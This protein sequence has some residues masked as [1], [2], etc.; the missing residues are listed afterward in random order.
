MLTPPT[1]SDRGRRLEQVFLDAVEEPAGAARDARLR[2]A[3]GDD[4]ALLDDA[5][6]LLAAH[7]ANADGLFAPSAE[8]SEGAAVSH[9]EEAPLSIGGYDVV[10]YV[11]GGSI[12]TVYE[13]RH[14]TTGRRAAVKLIRVGLATARQRARFQV[15]AELL[16]RLADPG[17]ARLYDAGEAAVTY[18]DGQQARRVFI[19]MEFVDG[20][21][22]V[23]HCRAARLPLADRVGLMI[24]TARAVQHAHERGVI[25]RDLK[26][27]HVIVA[28][29]DGRPRVVD[30]G[31]ATVTDPDAR[32]TLTGTVMGTPAYMSPEQRAGHRNQVGPATDVYSL[33]AV[34]Y[35]M[36]AD[37]R[38]VDAGAT[39]MGTG[40]PPD[41]RRLRSV[42]DDVPQD[43]DAVIHKAV[44]TDPAD[45]YPTARDLAD[46]LQR[47]ADSLPVRA[48]PPSA[49][50][51]ARLQARRRPR[52]TT[53]VSVAAV[54]G[55]TLGTA[56]ALEAVRANRAERATLAQLRVATG[57][58]VRADH[59]AR[60][61]AAVARFLSDQIIGRADA[62]K[63][64]HDAGGAVPDLT[65]RQAIDRAAARLD[66]SPFDGDAE[67]EVAVRRAVADAYVSLGQHDRAAA[68]YDRAAA[69]LRATPGPA[70]A[71]ELIGVESAKGEELMEV[72]RYHDAVAVLRRTYAA[73][74]ASLG[75]SAPA[76][77]STLNRLIEAMI[78]NGDGRQL[79]E[80]LRLVRLSVDLNRRV[81]GPTSRSTMQE[82]WCL[83][84]VLDYR[85]DQ[86]G[87]RQV[88]LDLA[89]V[90]EAT[91]DQ[92]R[93]RL[94]PDDP[95][96]LEVELGLAGTYVD[97]G[98]LDRGVAMLRDVLAR[99]TRLFGSDH[100][101][102]IDIATR[103]AKALE[104][105]GRFDQALPMA[106]MAQAGNERLHGPDHLLT[107]ASMK[108]RVTLLLDLKRYA[109]AEPVARDLLERAGRTEYPPLNF[110]Q[111]YASLL[112]QCLKAQGKGLVD[113][114][115][116]RPATRPSKG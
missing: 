6:R 111:T 61:S 103:L 11:D 112:D 63:Q 15:E 80:E 33:G 101:A 13:S 55:L 89:R 48:R 77:A 93:A 67:T 73:A 66:A 51:R 36:V 74:Q 95:D 98:Q 37:R 2:A 116:T 25:H 14:A 50:D 44:M 92:Y 97:V 31:I 42:A 84:L 38:M 56:T 17:I 59:Q 32:M 85:G 115:A 71:A 86:A 69:V 91:L 65:L 49:W 108:Q 72:G 9:G 94:G 21:D 105:A 39:A 68:Q 26:P 46:D 35:E 87:A 10:R 34:F 96:T 18:A 107:L 106:E 113:R 114:S 27:G 1:T 104:D 20:P 109:Q 83:G 24:A 100:S 7:D 82:M 8:V 88:R 76:T 53:A 23:A 58:R 110:P 19:A 29:G 28:R 22:V 99:R 4:P 43:L 30:F 40:A 62:S 54:A 5:R 78:D 52:L 12:G 16:A 45:R 70:A 75:P 3:C 90:G 47:W 81:F 79:D 41:P 57:E 64:L 60:V 102:T